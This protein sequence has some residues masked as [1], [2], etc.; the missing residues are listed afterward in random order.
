MAHLRRHDRAI[1]EP[2][3]IDA[4]LR[5]GRW[6]TIAMARGDE[7]YLVTMS[8]GYDAAARVLYF[9][10]AHEGQR[11]EWLSANPRVCA[12]IVDDRG[13]RDGRCEHEYASVVLRGTM[14]PVE[15]HEERRHGMR[16]LIGQLE[17]EP[18]DLYE[19]HELDGD[20]VYGRM[21]VLRLR[22]EEVTAKQGT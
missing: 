18:G 16:I 5:G 12:T 10:A 9:H 20:A 19:K 11:A 22:I 7:P 3:A 4:L 13:Y 15:D 2:E 14:A 21:A 8:Y 1:T 17:S 6:V